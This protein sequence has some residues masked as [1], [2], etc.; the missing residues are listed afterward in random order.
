MKYEVYLQD[1]SALSME[2]Q[3]AHQ[4]WRSGDPCSGY[5]LVRKLFSESRQSAFLSPDDWLCAHD[6]ACACGLFEHATALRRIGVKQFPDSAWLCVLSAWDLATDGKFFDCQ[7]MLDQCKGRF[8]TEYDGYFDAIRVLNYSVCG[9]RVSAAKAIE[10]VS[11]QSLD[12]PVVNYILSRSAV[13]RSQWEEAIRFGKRAVSLSPHWC[14]AR[15]ALAESL[16]AQGFLDE[17]HQQYTDAPSGAIPFFP[18]ELARALVLEACGERD[19]AI[20]ELLSVLKR[21]S[22]QSRYQRFGARHAALMLASLGRT[23]EAA[24]VLEKFKIRNF[25]VDRSGELDRR[26]YISLPLVA[27]N[28]NHC[29]PTV[30]AMV[31][32]SQGVKAN[33]NHYAIEMKTQSGTALW[34]MVDYMK[35]LGFEVAIV[36]SEAHVIEGL[37]NQGVAL[38][39]TLQG[40]FS[41][42]VEVINGFDANLKIAYI[43]DP[44]HWFGTCVRYEAIPHRYEESGGLVALIAPER[45]SR[46]E[47]DLDWLDE[48]GQALID[49]A[50]C[51][52]FGDRVGAERAYHAIPEDHPLV[53][54]R[55]VRGRGVVV[56]PRVFQEELQKRVCFTNPNPKARDIRLLLMQI[57]SENAERIRAIAESQR[58]KLGPLFTDYVLADCLVAES[59]WVE[60]EAAYDKLKNQLP[61]MDSMWSNYS[62]VLENLGKGAEAIEAIE[63]ALDIDPDNASLLHRL[64]SL[65]EN[66]IGYAE[67]YR[68]V[69]A[70]CERHA[71]QP[72][73]CLMMAQMLQEGGDGLLYEE[74]LKKCIR[75]YPR[76]PNYY[77]QLAGWYLVQSRLDLAKALVASAREFFGPEDLSMY[78][79]EAEETKGDVAENGLAGTDDSSGTAGGEELKKGEA[80]KSVD[81]DGRG[82]PDAVSAMIDELVEAANT[83]TFDELLESNVLKRL[84]EIESAIA[85]KW[86]QSARL[87]SLLVSKVIAESELSVMASSELNEKM[88][89]AFPASIPIGVPEHYAILLLKSLHE[90]V[91]TRQTAEFMLAW[92]ERCCSQR[93]QYPS[94]EFEVA[95]YQERMGLFNQAE[96]TLQSLLKKHPAY[97]PAL[98]RQGEIS[99]SRSDVKTAQR[100][101]EQA[102]ELNPSMVGALLELANIYSYESDPKELHYRELLLAIHPYS[103][104]RLYDVV[105]AS[106]KINNDITAALGVIEKYRDRF[107]KDELLWLEA[108]VRIDID[109]V[110]GAIAIAE[111]IDRANV[112]TNRMDWLMVDCHIKGED[113]ERAY[114]VV[115]G[116]HERAPEDIEILDQKIRLMRFL[117]PEKARKL[118]EEKI[119]EGLRIPILAHAALHEHSSPAARAI[120]LVESLAVDRRDTA[121]EMFKQALSRPQDLASQISFLQ[122][123]N[124][125][126]PHLVDLRETL[127]HRLSMQNQ[128]HQSTEIARSLLDSEPNNPRWLRLMG[129]SIQDKSPKES[130]EYLQREFDQTGSSDTLSRIAR[131]YQL[132]GDEYK[133]QEAYRK[134]L[135]INPLDA[136]AITNLH[137]KYKH[138]NA[139]LFAAA[140][141]AMEHNIGWD[142]QYFH[143]ITVEMALKL[144]KTVTDAWYPTAQR[145]LQMVVSEGGFRDEEARLRAALIAWASKRFD[146]EEC[147][148]YGGFVQRFKANWLWPRTAWVPAGSRRKR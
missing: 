53:I 117:H 51:C 70:I 22:I 86:W 9:W 32:E 122:W 60:A 125:Q 113:L 71:S 76:N 34:R 18:F 129:I 79:W 120:S 6:I 31:A 103:V 19:R 4:L 118:A 5:Q 116:M 144:K 1:S 15:N 61:Q 74:Y 33:P 47:I 100:C 17:G 46:V 126:L 121:A 127:V 72:E 85:M 134:V 2:M 138:C 90:F 65:Q 108:R 96:Q 57:D 3:Q 114:V 83:A 20:D 110:I 7:T 73:S 40:F 146:A 54:Q 102:V 68:R 137:Y 93:A 39:S 62:D 119:A 94:L 52:E 59:R 148:L 10:A 13:R 140:C 92:L 132:M 128:H 105:Y 91:P 84:L 135:S 23:A 112:D 99:L 24:E 82:S 28:F 88:A 97:A 36:K 42:H 142:D 123:C 50:R 64:T 124:L 107:G 109:D 77:S 136:M 11:T 147:K 49:L 12:N 30:A 69:K 43:R 56:T 58:E 21:W 89:K 14:R 45:K 143:V 130:V 44:M 55:S 66:S 29:V 38:I 145:R 48:A 131:G 8:G 139:E 75:F 87:R 101:F 80:P 106:A 26:Q 81:V 25:Q 78:S 41:S 63:H 115:E 35:S 104:A 141:A 67:Q 16:L 27:Q 95:Y 37:L 98:Y 133:A 111:K